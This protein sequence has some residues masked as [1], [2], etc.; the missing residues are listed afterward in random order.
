MGHA[1]KKEKTRAQIKLGVGGGYRRRATAVFIEEE[2]E[3][4]KGGRRGRGVGGGWEGKEKS[5]AACVR[6]GHGDTHARARM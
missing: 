1:K 4:E 2:K 6:S 5:G 3:E